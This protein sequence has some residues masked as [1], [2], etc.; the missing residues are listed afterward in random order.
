MVTFSESCGGQIMTD[1][2]FTDSNSLLTRRSAMSG[3]ALGGAGLMDRVEE[4]SR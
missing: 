2:K 1:K 4:E 3:L